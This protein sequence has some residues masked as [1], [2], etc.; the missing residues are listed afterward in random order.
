MKVKDMT[1]EDLRILISDTVEKTLSEVLN[2]PDRGLPLREEVE[3]RLRDSL[4]AVERGG[5]GIPLE[6][7]ARNIGTNTR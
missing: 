6:E 5:R 4:A 1:V 3:R 2:D 7:V